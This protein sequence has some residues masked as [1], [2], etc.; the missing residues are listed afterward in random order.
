MHRTKATTLK[1][2]ETLTEEQLVMLKE[3]EQEAF[4]AHGGIDEWVLVPLARHGCIILFQEEGDPR[5]VGVCEL[6]R[7]FRQPDKA[8]VYG[9]YIRE[10]KKG[11]GYGYTFLESLLA[12]LREDGFTK[13]CLTVGPEN[14]GAVA[15]YQK[16]GFQIIE[17][18]IAEYGSGHD[19][20]YMEKTL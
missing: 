14:V 19:R 6:M 12:Q 17:T 16:A 20:Y 11:L 8:Y 7:D 4:G 18:R 15:L 5:P 13:V 10:D 1:I 3:L 2:V 9:Y